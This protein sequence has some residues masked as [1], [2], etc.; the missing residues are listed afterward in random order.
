MEDDPEMGCVAGIF[1]PTSNEMCLSA[2]L[3]EIVDQRLA[4]L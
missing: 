2:V 3:D 4:L 1:Q